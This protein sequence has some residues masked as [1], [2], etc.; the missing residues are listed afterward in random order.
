MG[1]VDLFTKPI[2]GVSYDGYLMFLNNLSEYQQRAMFYLSRTL[3]EGAQLV[4]TVHD[5]LVL[6]APESVA[7]QVRS[8]TVE[9]MRYAFEKLFPGLPIE[10]EAKTCKRWSE[11]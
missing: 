5:E 7:E 3:P 4:A 2:R 1:L 8:K 9:A 10:V 6:E 11:K